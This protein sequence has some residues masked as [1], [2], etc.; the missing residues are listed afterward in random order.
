MTDRNDPSR[1]EKLDTRLK[2]ARQRRDGDGKRKRV[3]V[4]DF[5]PAIRV[6][7]DLVAGIIVG[8]LIGLGLD[9]WLGTGPWLMLLFFVLGAAAGIMNVMRT[10]GQIEKAAAV[11]RDKSRTADGDADNQTP[12]A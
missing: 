9:S 7:V 1:L 4:G 3:P 6:A 5:G 11:R 10:A 12:P 8:V 2:A